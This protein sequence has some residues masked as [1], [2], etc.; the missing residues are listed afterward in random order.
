MQM[1]LRIL[2]L[3]PQ[4]VFPMD[5]GGRISIANILKQFHQQGNDITFFCFTE[6]DIP[7]Q[8]MAEA[9]KYAKVRI[10]SHSTKNTPSRIA[11]A[12]INNKSIYIEKHS[13]KEIIDYLDELT[14]EESFDIVHADHTCMAPLAYHIKKRKKIRMGLRLHNI[15][16][17]IWYR[18]A[19]NLPDW[20]PKSFFIKQQ[21]Y[22]LRNVEREMISQ[23]DVCFSI[24]EKDREFAL[25]LSPSANV[26]T[27][28]GAVDFDVWALDKSIER[29]PFEIVLATVYSWVH[30][31]DG[32]K[33]FLD[34]VLPNV[35]N[36][37]PQTKLT[38][39]GKNPPAWLN[40]YKDQG[41]NIIGYVPEVQSYYNRANLYIVPLFVGS[42]LRFKILE[43]MAM[44]LPVITTDLGAE[45]NLCNE[46]DG[47]YRENSPEDFSN[48]IIELFDDFNRTREIGEKA[49]AAVQKN[50]SWENNVSIMLKEYKRL[51][52]KT[53]S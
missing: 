2:Q 14:D 15:E 44:E 42:G 43:A 22:L 3:A 17:M 21:A 12:V 4:F 33:W 52:A 11:K 49:R 45:G 29:E 26:I 16:W 24:T 9:E 41:V 37:F 34:N 53:T 51:S 46:E 30:N 40:S 28:S 50:Y 19:K 13:N 35:K 25:E 36:K 38:L 48:R 8:D 47:L 18:Y 39:I 23:A 10:F 27:A 31:I 20:H 32:L 7:E 6:D 1:S 5:D